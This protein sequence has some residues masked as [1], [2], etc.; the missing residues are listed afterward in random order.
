MPCKVNGRNGSI[1]HPDS[2]CGAKPGIFIE[3]CKRKCGLEVSDWGLG[4][5]AMAGNYRD[6]WRKQPAIVPI[7]NPQSP[8]RIT[9]K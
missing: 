7:P 2:Q 1:L 5:E 6:L 3:K 8:I 4:I 9:S